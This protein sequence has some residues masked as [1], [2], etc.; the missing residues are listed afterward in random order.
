M[1]T[2]DTQQQ[3][4][5]DSKSASA[6]ASKLRHHPE[7][8]QRKGL[9]E[10][11]QVEFFKYKRFIRSLNSPEYTKL[12]SSN[13]TLYPPIESDLD[14]KQIFIGLIK[15][16][17]IV[18]CIKLHH[19]ELKEH[20]LAPNKDFPQFLLSNRALLQPDEYYI[21]NYN[22][23]SFMDYLIVFGICS[24]VLTLVCYPL[25]PLKM[26]LG[27]YYLSYGVL[28]LLLAFLILALLRLFIYLLTLPVFTTEGGF[29]L[30]PNLF[31]DCSVL[32][33]FKPLYGFGDKQCYSSVKK[34]KKKKKRD[35]QNLI[36]KHN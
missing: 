18:P 20:N 27:V 22:P 7:L 14:A 10:N 23:K 21:W 25:W 35:L 4:E 19:D 11:R 32:D 33:S 31:E 12:S 30:F 34:L 24:G 3:V 17:L 6:I 2:S 8:K 13:F 16:Q 28:G 29:W 15:Q 26:R 5:V 36:K 9:F 1:S